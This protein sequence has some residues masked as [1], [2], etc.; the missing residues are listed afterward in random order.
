MGGDHTQDLSKPSEEFVALLCG[1]FRSHRPIRSPME[2]PSPAP[3][4]LPT[5]KRP[6]TRSRR[7][8]LAAVAAIVL[9]VGALAFVV[10]PVTQN[11]P[12]AASRSSKGV[13]LA[14]DAT[15]AELE[16]R[17]DASKARLKSEFVEN[18]K[19][20]AKVTEARERFFSEMQDTVGSLAD[21][22]SEEQ[23][24]FAA[25][26]QDF[27]ADVAARARE[28]ATAFQAINNTETLNFAAL[29][30]EGA[31]DERRSQVGTYAQVAADYGLF[32][33]GLMDTLG[34]RLAVL[35]PDNSYAIG[36]IEGARKQHN[37]Q[38]PGMEAVMQ[39]HTDYAAQLQAML[40]FLE[41]A[42]DTW[43]EQ[44]GKIHFQHQAD[45]DTFNDLIRQLIE[46]ERRLNE[47]SRK[48]M[49]AV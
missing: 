41:K 45:L 13:D 8:V 21:T 9:L 5:A 44:D 40:D 31:F 29:R 19:D 47:G 14:N 42:M 10:G 28:L 23:K 17:I 6:A 1:K 2:E 26:M 12:E 3:P 11:V 30:S 48:L 37:K 38:Q 7:R 46:I 32:Y 20:T 43:H 36:A 33:S 25:V 49:E 18:Q 16:Q 35:G 39:A 34:Q 4:P 15:A 22:T 27:L 24:R